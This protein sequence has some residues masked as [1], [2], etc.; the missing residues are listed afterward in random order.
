MVLFSPMCN[1]LDRVQYIA[2]CRG[3]NF[4]HSVFWGLNVTFFYD[5]SPAQSPLPS[6]S[7]M[8]SS[9]E[10]FQTDFTYSAHVPA[11]PLI[12]VPTDVKQSLSDIWCSAHVC[13]LF[14]ARK[15]VLSQF[16]PLDQGLLNTC[17][18][19]LQ[20]S[21]T[22]SWCSKCIKKV[23]M[24]MCTRWLGKLYNQHVKLSWRQTVAT[25]ENL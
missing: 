8:R 2:L 9:P 4:W 3:T 16:F 11:F 22:S 15:K 18:C 23:M 12:C 7:F 6:T 20:T 14:E 10:A 1:S 17:V 25:L 19:L 24:G 21:T 13:Y 5:G